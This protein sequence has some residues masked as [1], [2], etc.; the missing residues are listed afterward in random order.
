M[1]FN[2]KVNTTNLSSSILMYSFLNC[3]QCIMYIYTHIQCARIKTKIGVRGSFF[4]RGEGLGLSEAY[5]GGF[6]YVNLIKLDFPDLWI[7]AYAYTSKLH[8]RYATVLQVHVIIIVLKCSFTCICMKMWYYYLKVLQWQSYLH[9]AFNK[10]VEMKCRHSKTNWIS[11]F[12]NV[13]NHEFSPHLSSS[14]SITT[15][16]IPR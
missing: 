1:K 11:I 12:I 8:L 15:L 10:L 16:S 9:F 5:F 13:I 2:K 3:Y 6:Y 4:F 14:M 7:H